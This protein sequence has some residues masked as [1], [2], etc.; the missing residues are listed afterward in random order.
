MVLTDRGQPGTVC[1]QLGMPVTDSIAFDHTVSWSQFLQREIPSY[2]P[3]GLGK[4]RKKLPLW[5]E[6]K[7]GL[8]DLGL[9]PMAEAIA[10]MVASVATY[11]RFTFLSP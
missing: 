8:L 7:D 3:A 10:R 1:G 4:A 11:P 2:Q 6:V 5:G 9:E